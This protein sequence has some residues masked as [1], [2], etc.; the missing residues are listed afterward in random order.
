VILL[1]YGLLGGLALYRFTSPET[2]GLKA[3][4]AA[5]CRDPRLF[6][7]LAFGMVAL[8]ENSR[9]ECFD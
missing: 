6:I 2:E 7:R 1:A 5:L 9:L 3:S 8:I 4:S